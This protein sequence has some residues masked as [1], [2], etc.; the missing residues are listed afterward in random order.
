MKRHPRRLLIGS[1]RARGYDGFTATRDMALCSAS[2]SS[3]LIAVVRL[4]Q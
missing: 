1:R 4:D 2:V 3:R